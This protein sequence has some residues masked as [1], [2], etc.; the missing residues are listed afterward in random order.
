MSKF[1]VPFG[2]GNGCVF[3]YSN[4]YLVDSYGVYAARY[5]SANGDCNVSVS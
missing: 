5:V 1:V 4:N 2:C 3:I